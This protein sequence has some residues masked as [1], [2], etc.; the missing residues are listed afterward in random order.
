MKKLFFLSNFLIFLVLFNCFSSKASAFNLPQKRQPRYPL[1]LRRGRQLE[2][3]YKKLVFLYTTSNI[4]SINDHLTYK[5]INQ[6]TLQYQQNILKKEI[7]QL[8][9]NIQKIKLQTEIEVLQGI[10]N[11]KCPARYMPDLNRYNRYI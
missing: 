6:T 1:C 11:R 7:S 5:P 3:V 8:E 10:I 9:Y 2:N 4:L